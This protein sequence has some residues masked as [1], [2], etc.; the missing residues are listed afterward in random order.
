MSIIGGPAVIRTNPI[1]R[2]SSRAKNRVSKLGCGGFIGSTEGINDLSGSSNHGTFSGNV[3][4]T[5]LSY[6]TTYALTYPETSQTPAAREGLTAG[7]NNITS[8]KYQ[9]YGRGLNVSVYDNDSNVWLPSSYFNGTRSSG[10]CYD[11]YNSA[12]KVAECGQFVTDYDNIKTQFPNSIYVMGASHA[13][14]YKTPDMLNRIVDCGG[15]T[16]VLGWSASSRLEWVL[17]GKPGSGAGK[18]Y[19][20]VLQNNSSAVAH[21]NFGVP[22]HGGT[23]L[24]FDGVDGNINCGVIDYSNVQGLTV[25]CWFNGNVGTAHKN[26]LMSSWGPSGSADYAWLLFDSWWSDRKLDFLV[27]ANGTAYTGVRTASQV[28][29]NTWTYVTAT[30]S[31]AAMKIYINGVLDNTNTA[32]IPASIMNNAYATLLGK[33]DDNAG[34]YWNGMLDDITINGYTQSDPEILQNFNALRGR[35]GL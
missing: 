14:D 18:A 12:I 31:P 27:S 5:G 6:Y 30:W 24:E 23:S 10:R 4:L 11:N 26:T 28:P 25:S 15:P 2:Y 33:D 9:D 20:F 21:L 16:S 35:Y 29:T 13:S 7:Y 32:N 3:K 22:R 19:G 1:L 17:V 8:G 34:R